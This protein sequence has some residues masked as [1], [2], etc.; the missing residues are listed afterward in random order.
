[1][2]S[3]ETYLDKFYNLRQKSKPPEP[4]IR[5]QIISAVEHLLKT[6]H[7]YRFLSSEETD[8]V[9]TDAILGKFD[10]DRSIIHHFDIQSVNRWF[11][12]YYTG[13]R[14]KAVK[15]HYI[16]TNRPGGYDFKP[17]ETDGEVGDIAIWF[18][19]WRYLT[20]KHMRH[21]PTLEDDNVLPQQSPAQSREGFTKNEE[22]TGCN[23]LITYLTRP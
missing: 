11:K 16:E 13:D 4:M 2:L 3:I 8:K 1:M 18:I 14:L 20:S 17:N 5:K 9:F 23:A 21:Q 19:K 6:H 12:A 22:L 15:D 7:Q 10:D